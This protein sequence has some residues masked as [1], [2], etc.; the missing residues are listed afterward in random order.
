MQ[1][2]SAWMSAS[3]NEQSLELRKRQRL[4]LE[5]A[6]QARNFLTSRNRRSRSSLVMMQ[7][8]LENWAERTRQQELAYL[9]ATE[10][11]CFVE[12]GRWI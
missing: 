9:L 3:E 6:A 10:N 8:N 7:P 11:R 4:S 5:T 1:I 2:P 12:Y